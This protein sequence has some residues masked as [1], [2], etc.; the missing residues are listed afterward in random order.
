M[1]YL[2]NK[3]GLGS[4][5]DLGS[6]QLCTCVC[7]SYSTIWGLVWAVYRRLEQIVACG[8]TCLVRDQALAVDDN[9]LTHQSVTRRQRLL[10]ATGELD[11]THVDPIPE[12]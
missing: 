7:V 2:E 11:R 9:L 4:L 3:K 6:M 10:S 5:E 12:S 8:E 1:L